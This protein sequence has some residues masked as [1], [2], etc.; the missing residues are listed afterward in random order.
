VTDVPHDVALTRLLPAET[1]LCAVLASPRA[2]AIGCVVSLTALGWGALGL[3]AANDE[4]W[5]ALCRPLGAGG[6]GELL[7]VLGMWAAMT[8]AMMLPSAGPMILTY[9]EIADTAAGKNEPAASPLLL[10]AGYTAVWLGFAVAAT[11]L[12]FALTQTAL[13]DAG[14]I[15]LWLAAGLFLGAGLYQFSALKHACLTQC[16]RPFPFFFANWT[17]EPR[18]VFRLGLRQGLYCLGCCFAAMLIMFA[19]GAMNVVWMAILAILMTVEKMT[20]TTQFSRIVGTGF[21]AIGLG[22]AVMALGR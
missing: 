15:S 16:Q 18:G 12:Q 2:I 17:S 21:V 14:R 10:A 9:A 4:V 11:L 6:A 1:R 7:L 22:I 3:M 8:L 13:L 19:A 20:T 5:L